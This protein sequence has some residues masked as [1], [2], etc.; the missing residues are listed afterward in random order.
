MAASP[1][2][3]GVTCSY[4]LDKGYTPPRERATLLAA[5]T[6]AVFAAGGIPL[7]LPVPR[8]H[9]DARLDALL[10]GVQGLLFTGG[11]DVS[12]ERY[13]ESLHPKT[14]T[15]HPVRERF[16]FDLFRRADERRIP[17]FA[18]C[19]GFQVAHVARGGRLIQHVDDLGLAPAIAHHQ[20]DGANA[21]HAVRVEP[22]TQLMKIV[23]ARDFEVNSRHHQAVDAQ[24]TGRGLRPAGWSP[25]GLLEASEDCEGRFLLAVQWHPEDLVDRPEHL[26]LFESLVA[27][28]REHATP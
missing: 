9:D 20:P 4:G 24:H 21:F 7:P 3:I 2:L 8:M 18:I 6:E 12:P 14:E 28:A 10:A 15:M 23:G 1:P 5:Y 13:G 16:E 19:L 22:D 26:R 25:D 27:E 11:Y 17:I